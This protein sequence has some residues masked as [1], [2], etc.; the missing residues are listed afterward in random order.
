MKLPAFFE[1]SFELPVRATYDDTFV[2]MSG[3]GKVSECLKKVVYGCFPWS[4]YINLLLE[5]GGILRMT[6]KI[7]L[8][9]HFLIKIL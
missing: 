1:G 2:D 3:W 7:G 4:I 5:H 8:T 6:I 9:R